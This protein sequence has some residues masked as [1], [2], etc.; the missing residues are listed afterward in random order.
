M[1]CIAPMSCIRKSPSILYKS[2]NVPLSIAVVSSSSYV[3]RSIKT[4]KL[5][6]IICKKIHLFWCIDFWL[7]ISRHPESCTSTVPSTLN[8]HWPL[9]DFKDI[10]YLMLGLTM[11]PPLDTSLVPTLKVSKHLTICITYI[12]L[13]SSKGGTIPVL[14]TQWCALMTLE[15]CGQRKT[16]PQSYIPG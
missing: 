11:L 16:W 2:V 12:I 5:R 14:P 15:S 3:V 10:Q 6:S 1:L 13:I 4:K 9:C 8:P 7:I